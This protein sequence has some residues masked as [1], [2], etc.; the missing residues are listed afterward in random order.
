MSEQGLDDHFSFLGRFP[1][2]QMPGFFAQ[3]DAML[4][5]LKNIP[6][7]ALTVPYKVQCYLACGRP[8]IAALDGEGARIIQASGS[9]LVA[10]PTDPSALAACVAEMMDASDECRNEFARSARSF[11]EENFSRDMTYRNLLKWLRD[12]FLEK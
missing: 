9:G 11:F 1:E 5:T 2:D 8:I 12:P 4:V 6:I 10:R 3:A 7:W